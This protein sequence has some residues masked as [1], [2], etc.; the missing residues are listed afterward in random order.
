[1]T[2]KPRVLLIDLSALF[3]P[4]WR[5]NEN[6][7]LS[8]AFEGTLGGVRRC[9]AACEPGTLVAVCCDGKG[10]W[11]KA[12]TPTYKAHREALPNVFYSE[13]DRVKERLRADGLLLW[14]VDGYEADDLIAQATEAATHAG[15]CVRIASHDKD[16]LQLVY[17]GHVDYLSTGSFAIMTSVETREKFGVV[18]NALGDWL[19]LVGDKADGVAG[20]PGCGPVNAAKLLGQFG[21]LRGVFDAAHDP[22][23]DIKPAMRAAIIANDTQIELAR[24]LVDFK[25]DAPIRFE[26]IYEERRPQPLT[27]EET[28]YMDEPEDSTKV[29]AGPKETT[30]VVPLAPGDTRTQAPDAEAPQAPTQ[31]L[32][33]VEYSRGLEPRT[34]R[35]AYDLAKGLF[36]SRLYQRFANAEA[37]MAVIIRGREMGLGALTSLDAF[38]VIEGKPAP[39]AY[40]IIARA[41]ADPDCE[42]LQCIDTTADGSTW[43][44]KH[45]KNPQPTR[46]RYTIQQATTAGLVKVG[47]NW[48]KRPDEMCR[49]TA[50]VQLARMEYPDAALGLY[51]WEELGGE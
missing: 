25:T 3:H 27:T 29:T 20:C 5:A 46:L 36:D 37:I 50:G 51:S 12:L 49:K 43:E 47:G 1:M 28:T 15:H 10:N 8:V 17:D 34:I 7:P 31:A 18:P 48:T 11:R 4:A 23:S 44:T 13:F 22:E 41:K 24:K 33:T 2:D 9:I 21:N 19:A 40:L 30:P 42:Y 35:G 6:G 32:V 26:E 38:H 39:H 16:M 45:R 14:Q